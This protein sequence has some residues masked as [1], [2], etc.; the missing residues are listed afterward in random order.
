[1][2]EV[3]IKLSIESREQTEKKLSQLGFK[4]GKLVEE[5]DSY[6]NSPFHD[7]RET[8]EAL[9]IRR[10][11]DHTNGKSLAVITYKGPKIDAVSM[12]RCELESEVSDPAICGEILRSLGFFPV[13]PVKKMRR[14]Y[15]RGEVTACVDQVEGLGDF[16]EL[17]IL[18]PTEKDRINALDQ[19]ENTL[20]E[21]GHHMTETTRIS[22]LSMLQA[23]EHFGGN[24]E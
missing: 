6:F 5:S 20:K 15:H 9:R 7:F 13:Q 10:S 11:T 14:Y 8:D 23:K 18:V 21:L 19:M 2:I 3:E 1:M 22:Y 17:E 12:T 24:N 4:K 16:L